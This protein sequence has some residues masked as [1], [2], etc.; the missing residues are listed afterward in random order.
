MTDIKQRFETLYG[1]DISPKIVSQYEN[2]IAKYQNLIGQSKEIKP[3][4]NEKDIILITY[5]DMVNN[6]GEKTLKTLHNWLKNRLN[7]TTNIVHFLPFFPSTSDGGFAVSDYKTINPE[8]GNWEDVANIKSD[9]DLMFDFVIN[10]CSASHFWFKEYLKSNSPYTEYFIEASPDDERLKKVTRARSHPLLT[11]FMTANGEK[12]LWTTFSTD[13]ID[14]NF[15]NPDVLLAYL[16]ILLFYVS[17][18]MR[19]VRLDALHCCY[20]ELGTSCMSLPQTHEVCKILRDTV[21]KVAPS[22]IVLTET[23]LPHE[24]NISY[25]GNGDE[26]EMVYQFALPPLILYAL[27]FEDASLLSLWAKGLDKIPQDCTFLN[28]TASHDG[29]GVRAL[30]KL[31]PPDKFKELISVMEA[32]GA[33]INTRQQQDG[34][35]TPYEICTTYFDAF[36]EDKN[37]VTSKQIKKFLCSQCIPLSLAGIPAFYFHSFTSC[38]NNYEGLSKTNHNRDLNRYK[39][40]LNELD[41]HLNSGYGKQIFET[42]K[43]LIILRKQTPEF[44]PDAKMEIVDLDKSLF[45]VKR[46]NSAGQKI[47]AIHNVSEK[48]INFNLAKI[49]AK[50]VSIINPLNNQK[51]DPS[52]SILTLNDFD[53]YWIKIS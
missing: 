4:W 42:L 16:D 41:N 2:L 3:K 48:T 36:S 38:S 37:N 8:F 32:K 49:D 47:I 51:I 10:H 18:G 44:H 6:T 12:F 26:A 34:S 53:V 19:I 40:Q 33:K 21:H 35:H 43:N 30:E 22:V 15:K 7:D 28:F 13:Q 27:T 23:N 45:I 5:A 11:P 17:K 39:W 1:E 14:V 24:E 50:V 52:N 9:F 46:E 20:K 25:F 31:A 29:I